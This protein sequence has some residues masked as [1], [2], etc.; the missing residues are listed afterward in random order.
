MVRSL[1]I[2]EYIYSHSPSPPIAPPSTLTVHIPFPVVSCAPSFFSN[3]PLHVGPKVYLAELLNHFFPGKDLAFCVPS[4]GRERATI[5]LRAGDNPGKSKSPTSA[6]GIRGGGGAVQQAAISFS[7]TLAAASFAAKPPRKAEGGVLRGKDCWGGGGIQADEVFAEAGDALSDKR[8]KGVNF[9]ALL[10][11][12]CQVK[13]QGPQSSQPPTAVGRGDVSRDLI[14]TTSG[15]NLTQPKSAQTPLEAQVEHDAKIPTKTDRQKLRASLPKYAARPRAQPIADKLS[16]KQRRTKNTGQLAT[17]TLNRDKRNSIESHHSYFIGDNISTI[18]GRQRG[19][20]IVYVPQSPNPGVWTASVEYNSERDI[21]WVLA[22]VLRMYARENIPIKR[23][24][25]LARRPQ[26]LERPPT[27]WGLFQGKQEWKLSPALPM[28]SPVY[29]LLSPG[30]E[31][32]VLVEGF[33]PALAFNPRVSL[34]LP[35]SPRNERSS[36]VG[37]KGAASLA[38]NSESDFRP[39]SSIID[40]GEAKTSRERLVEGVVGR[41][42]PGSF[43]LLPDDDIMGFPSRRDS[44]LRRV[45][46]RRG[47]HVTGSEKPIGTGERALHYDSPTIKEKSALDSAP[48]PGIVKGRELGRVV[49]P[50]SRGRADTSCSAESTIQKNKALQEREGDERSCS[51][52]TLT[53]ED[54]KYRAT[55]QQYSQYGHTEGFLSGSESA[56]QSRQFSG[57]SET[58]SSVT[59][60]LDRRREE[61]EVCRQTEGR[62]ENGRRR[63][64]QDGAGQTGEERVEEA[65]RFSEP[66]S[67]PRSL[68]SSMFSAWGAG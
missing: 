27:V 22:E 5:K 13:D 18:Q 20:I 31:L 61:D 54:E 34:C 64:F 25:G 17:T 16:L 21:A 36:S 38:V 7:T 62:E 9:E 15:E 2:K 40:C 32:V 10:H 23:Q 42:P 65:G 11:R 39:I 19:S 47:G 44:S 57:G 45:N 66:R 33:D 37:W 49:V 52:D 29:S 43:S 63:S 59:A 60:G 50:K 24:T 3:I 26:L 67:P 51:D 12:A 41:T 14:I 35:P 58:G 1:T 46:G 53:D 56:S 8:L 48:T 30:E 6:G 68:L 55:F 4:E 28:A